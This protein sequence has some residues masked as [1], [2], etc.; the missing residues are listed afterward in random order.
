MGGILI[1]LSLSGSDRSL[2]GTIRSS[3]GGNIAESKVKG[4]YDKGSRTMTL[5]DTDTK[6]L[7]SGRYE[8]HLADDSTKLTGS[9]IRTAG[10]LRRMVLTRSK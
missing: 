2:H 1:D 4:S 7:S 10:G 8:L 5:R 3:F 6:A 9:F